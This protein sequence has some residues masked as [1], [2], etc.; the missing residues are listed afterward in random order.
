[1]KILKFLSFMLFNTLYFC[2][3][4][5]CAYLFYRWIFNDGLNIH[6]YL[7]DFKGL[8]ILAICIIFIWAVKFLIFPI[9]LTLIPKVKHIELSEKLE[10]YMNVANKLSRFSFL[11]DFGI[12]LL[13]SGY[14]LFV[15]LVLKVCGLNVYTFLFVYFV[16]W[17]LCGGGTFTSYIGLVF[18]LKAKEIT[19]L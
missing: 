8:L 3:N 2:I 15:S 6:I 12:F 18:W 17:M 10:Y 5:F 19:I 14:A 13:I 4:L 16:I 9:F 7:D 1:M 11:F